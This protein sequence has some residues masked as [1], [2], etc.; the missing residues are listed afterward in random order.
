MSQLYSWRGCTRRGCRWR[1]HLNTHKWSH[2]T[3][4]HL[5][6][7]RCRMSTR[8]Q[9]DLHRGQG[10][11]CLSTRGFVHQGRWPQRPIA[12]TETSKATFAACS[13]AAW[14]PIICTLYVPSYLDRGNIGNAKTAGADDDL[15][16]DSQ[17]WTW[18]LNAFYICDVLFEWTTI[19]WKIFP[20]HIYVAILCLCWGIAAMCSGAVKN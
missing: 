10:H 2:N 14:L 13:T 3:Q 6:P 9:H 5:V 12:V 17:Q 20:A 18:I 16:L 8:L 19:L 11:G 15:G 7:I 1:R 4:A